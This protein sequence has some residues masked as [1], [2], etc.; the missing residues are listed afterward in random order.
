MRALVAESQRKY[1]FSSYVV[2]GLVIA[3]VMTYVAVMVAL[4]HG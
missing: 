3:I 1:G 2:F 4:G